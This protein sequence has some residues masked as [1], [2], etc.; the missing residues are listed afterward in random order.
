MANSTPASIP[1]PGTQVIQQFMAVTPTVIT[2]T[3]VPNV[4][5]VCKQIVDLLVTDST[6]GQT[7][8]ADALIDLPAFFFSAAATGSPPVYT[9]LD[10]LQLAVSINESVEVDLPF[11]D[12]S[13][14]GLTPATMVSQIMAALSQQGVTS[15]QA[16]LVSDTY[17]EFATL[18]KGQFESITILD[19]TSPVVASALGIGIGQTY[20][21]V[22]NYNQYTL[23]IPE[24]AF[25]DPRNNL[26][27]LVIEQN[28]VRVFLATGHSTDITEATRTASFLMKGTVAISGSVQSPTDLSGLVYPT[29]IGTNNLIINVDNGTDQTIAFTSP[30]SDTAFLSQ[31]Q[32]GLSG[33]TPS[34][35]SGKFLEIT[36]NSEGANSSVTIRPASTLLTTNG[37]PL[38]FPVLAGTGTSI[39]AVS[40]GSGGAYTSLLDFASM[41]F[42]AAATHAVLTASAPPTFSA[43]TTGST[44]ILSD[45]HAPQTIT[46]AGN[47]TTVV[48]AT[49]SLQATIQALV[50]TET[51]G[52]VVVSSTGGALTLTNETVGDESML[53]IVGGT[54]LAALDPGTT[55]TLIAGA[56]T[57]GNPF[58]PQAGDQIWIDGT[59]FAL[60]NKVAPGGITT[61]LKINQQVPIST[62]VGTSFYIEA[63][64]LVSPAPPNRPTPDLVVDLTDNI[65]IKHSLLRDFVGNPLAVQA[66]IYVAYTALRL[67][68]TALA[69]NPGLLRFG[70]TT[71]LEAAIGPTTADNPLALGMY[72]ALINGPGIQVTGLGVDAIASEEPFGTVEAFTRA[73]EY[74][75]GFEVYAIALLTHDE[76]V[77]QVFNTH[78]QFMSQPEQHG[79]RIL[80]WNPVIPT[81]ALD[82]LITSGTNGDGLSTITFD[83]KITS[84]STLLQ[85]AGVSPVG[86]IPVASGL[87]LALAADGNNYSIA[88]IVGSR[89]T[90][91]VSAG[92]F[93]NGSNDDGFYAENVLPSPL[94]GELFSIRVRGLPL[95]TLA[96]TPDKNAIAAN[97][98]AMGQSFQNRRF[99]MTLPDRCVATISG[100]SQVLDGFYMNAATA[101]AIGQQPP[102]QSFTQF[103]ITGFTGVKGSNDTYSE[104]QLNVMAGGG[105]YIFVQDVANAPIYARMALTTDLTS[106]ETRTD[107]VTKIVDFTAKF[108]RG[109]LKNFIGRFNITQGFLD[110]LGTVGQGLFGFLT[111]NGVLIGGSLDNIIQDEN[112]RDTVIMDST[113][114]VPIPC[115]YLKLTLLI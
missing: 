44:L 87:F 103:P 73:A 88:S 101:G 74:L 66:P 13:A 110:T 32:A 14:E 49:N 36:S 78:V 6:G 46:F 71:D 67:D 56:Q 20:L 64:N 72:F 104:S 23:T 96:G 62:N 40:D 21:G 51:G 1:R 112:N 41:N 4:V 24:E 109:S 80:L 16:I 22:S 27:E 54:A 68:T 52:N 15:A 45:G 18:G 39:A 53:Q 108:V 98:N 8:N 43:L 31:L 99:W 95:V 82:T 94:I 55:P 5:G 97:V 60:V 11:S 92:S 17:F 7:L 61:R 81:N 79:E 48:G 75:E 29:A 38:S 111:E 70:N 106:V 10:G 77:A 105:A 83:T 113:L 2:P 26:A 93:P 89:V 47:E 85:A 19:T 90:V 63:Q 115:N 86:T 65:T 12:P 107:S 69:T 59:L 9:G 28:T 84:L 25:P 3:L 91:R 42:T 57:N 34:L 102:Q 35:V 50:G 76:S 37:G 114:D 58:P 100:V 33:A 30:A